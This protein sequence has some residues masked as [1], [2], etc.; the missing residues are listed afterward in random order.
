[1]TPIIAVLLDFLREAWLAL[2]GAIGIIAAL[3]L[4]SQALK[5]ASAGAL[6]SRFLVVQALF[7]W[8]GIL[9]TTLFAFLGVPAIVEAAVAAVPGEAGCG[10][11][12]SLGLVAGALVG[13]L[14]GL[15]MLKAL[16]AS[17]VAA[18]AGGAAALSLSLLEVGEA[19]V[20]MILASAAIP[21][22]AHFL[23]VC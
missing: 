1:M 9:G 11:I 14:A 17:A 6:G 8:L 3:G 2:G 10:P 23:G 20:G 21:I 22:A 7:A 4:L 19:V 12:A 15:R 16:L 18:A 13:S 5:A